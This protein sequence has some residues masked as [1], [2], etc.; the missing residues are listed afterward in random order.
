M[1]HNTIFFHGWGYS[2]DFWQSYIKKSGLQ[3]ASCYNRGYFGNDH[4]PLLKQG[5]NRCVT[6]SS[7][8]LFASQE[9]DLSAFNDIIIYAGFEAFPN[10][11]ALKAMRLKMA[12]HNQQLQVISDFYTLCG[13][14]PNIINTVIDYGKLAND[15][16]LLEEY[17]ITTDINWRNLSHYTA[18][19][20]DNDPIITTPLR[21][22]II[23]KNT[24]HL[25]NLIS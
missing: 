21:G 1:E 13:Y 8:L 5:Y 7:G 10:K 11:I 3:S 14:V 22:A 23:L 20:G 24:G 2:G 16:K 19:H 4:K 6:H 25:C 17:N 18:Y 12:K 9:Y 15:L